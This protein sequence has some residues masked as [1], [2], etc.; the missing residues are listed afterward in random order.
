M[1]KS[2]TGFARAQLDGGDFSLTLTIKSVNHRSLD[3]QMRLPAELEA[4]EVE[5]RNAI[6]KKLA[7]G[8]VQV[9]AYIEMQGAA[10]LKIKRPIVEGYLAAYQELARDYGITAEPDLSALFRLPGILSYGETDRARSAEMQKALLET[11]ARALD[12]LS[13]VRERE[14]AGI[15]EEMERRSQAIGS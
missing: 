15:I 12:E 8:A 13:R 9:N 5:A 3:I 2:M 14:A 11:L 10:T 6:K 1:P 7:R 4:F